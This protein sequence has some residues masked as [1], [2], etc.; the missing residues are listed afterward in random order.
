MNHTHFFAI[1]IDGTLLNA[2]HELSQRTQ[3]AIRQIRAAGHRITIATG[4][5]ASSTLPIARQLDLDVPVICMNG[6]DIVDPQTGDSLHIQ[7]IA[8]DALARLSARLAD[9]EAEFFML[10]HRF[11]VSQTRPYGSYDTIWTKS[12]VDYLPRS[13]EPLLKATIACPSLQLQNELYEELSQ[14]QAFD[15]TRSLDGNIYL[16]AYAI[17]KL[18]GIQTLCADWGIPLERV[19]AFGNAENDLDMLQHVGRGIAMANSD[20]VILKHIKLTT[21]S[22]DEDGVACELERFLTETATVHEPT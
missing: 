12:L 6:S 4:R 20:P 5:M 13:A 2:Q 15:M 16:T 17:T 21:K 19:T 14:W 8:T 3:T 10:G 9:T 1:D 22:N 7:P 11:A 18:S